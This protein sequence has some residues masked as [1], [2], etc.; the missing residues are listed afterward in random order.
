[1]SV[2]IFQRFHHH[3]V[4][5]DEDPPQLGLGFYTLR[6]GKKPHFM[7]RIRIIIRSLTRTLAGDQS[8]SSIRF[9]LAGDPMTEQILNIWST[10]DVP[11]KSGRRE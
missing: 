9:T 7:A 8:E 1:M 6:L 10:S 3:H 4:V 2:R 11:G 5:D